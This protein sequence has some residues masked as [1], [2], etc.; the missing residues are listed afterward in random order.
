[1][2]TPQKS[3]HFS[4]K[5]VFV[6]A[7]IIA[8]AADLVSK[9]LVVRISPGSVLYNSGVAFSMFSSSLNMSIVMMFVS[10]IVGVILLVIT[11]IKK[12]ITTTFRLG[13]LLIASGAFANGCDRVFN[14]MHTSS[15]AAVTDFINW[16]GL[17]TGNIADIF[18]V[19]GSIVLAVA[20][21]LDIVKSGR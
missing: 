17:V 18:V 8:V 3:Q 14:L 21:M 10:L 16:G 9:W 5:L 4:S 6:L 1:M 12:Q 13:T 15:Q 19:V 20:I 2:T 7:F 11:I